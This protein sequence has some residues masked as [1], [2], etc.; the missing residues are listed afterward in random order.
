[1]RP[2]RGTIID[3]LREPSREGR[4]VNGATALGEGHPM[5][6]AVEEAIKGLLMACVEWLI[7]QVE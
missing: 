5:P 6:P 3:P 4:G 2:T 7:V 1:M